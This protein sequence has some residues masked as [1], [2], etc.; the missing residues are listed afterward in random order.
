MRL[1]PVISLLGIGIDAMVT[2]QPLTFQRNSLKK[3]AADP[4]H[5]LIYAATLKNQKRRTACEAKQLAFI[6]LPVSTFGAWHSDAA[7]HLRDLA[8]LQASRSGRDMGRAIKHL[9]ERLS[10]LLQRGNSNM[11]FLLHKE[12]G[13]QCH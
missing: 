13:P 2:T 9:F 8:R 10:I 5:A 7:D 3:S 1:A 6:P 4:S 11:L 12:R